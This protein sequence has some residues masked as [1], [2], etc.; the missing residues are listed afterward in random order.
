MQHENNLQLEFSLESKII[1][2][3]LL[4]ALVYPAGVMAVYMWDIGGKWLKLI[5]LFPFLLLLPFFYDLMMSV[6]K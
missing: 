4:L 6:L 3:V 2:T 5:V 1:I